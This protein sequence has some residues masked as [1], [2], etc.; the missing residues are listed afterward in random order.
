MLLVTPPLLSLSSR[1]RV[2]MAAH[3]LAVALYQARATARLRTANVGLKLWVTSK[4]VEYA[5][6]RDGN[7][8]GVRTAEI[9]S[10]VDP[11]VTPRRTFAHFG[12]RVGFG[13][14]PGMRPRDPGDPARR[15]ERLDDPI[16]FNNSDIATFGP[17]GTSTPGSL[18]VSDG[19][20]ELAVV[21][22][23]GHTGKVKVL[24]W[25]VATDA[26]IP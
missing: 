11:Q 6:F 12:G 21:R 7:D 10:G 3:E 9:A 5:C 13:F 20:R 24:R 19:R 22:V 2:D 25:D 1:L 8:N 16:R 15:L 18:Y 26:W 4:G 23:L 14:P 17:L